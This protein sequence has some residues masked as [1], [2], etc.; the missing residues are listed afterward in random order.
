MT[1]PFVREDYLNHA[2]RLSG[3]SFKSLSPT[4]NNSVRQYRRSEHIKHLLYPSI[5]KLLLTCLPSAQ[6]NRTAEFFLAS[7]NVEPS[8]ID[9]LELRKGSDTAFPI[10]NSNYFDIR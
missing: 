1:L 5:I 8:K 3:N 6:H 4:L 10:P 2:L 9:L 7:S